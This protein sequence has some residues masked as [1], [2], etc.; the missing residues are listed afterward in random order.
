MPKRGKQF[1]LGLSLLLPF[2]LQS[3]THYYY[4]P[5]SNNIPLLEKKGDIK[6]SVATAAS[7][8]TTGVE[9]QSAFA[10]SNHI[11]AMAN[12]YHASGDNSSKNSS[13][14]N[15]SKGAGTY[16]EFGGG[17]FS[18]INS[19]NVIFE[20]YGGA[21]AG[22][23][24]NTYSSSESSKVNA[25]KYF[26]QPSIGFSN[27]AHTLQVAVSSRFSSVHFNLINTIAPSTTETSASSQLKDLQNNPDNIFW[28]PAFLVR[29]GLR[30][31]K[32]QLQYTAS[33]AFKS[34]QYLT[35]P[36]IVSLGIFLSF[37]LISNNRE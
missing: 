8:E 24:T 33:R 6:F 15:Y 21:G 30:N 36:E 14:P 11:G 17:Y 22:S 9:L 10:L 32:F 35:Q 29:G 12:F 19:S 13:T 5:N 20:I 26:I 7:S 31:A 18:A 2:C 16:A 1:S 28:E 27:N 37:N 3:C 4:G 23:I 25:T 34:R